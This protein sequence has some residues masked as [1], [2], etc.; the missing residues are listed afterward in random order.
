MNPNQRLPRSRSLA[1]PASFLGLFIAVAA[2]TGCYGAASPTPARP[3]LPPIVDGQE[4]D[5]QTSENPHYYESGGHLR[6]T[7]GIS[8]DSMAYGDTALTYHE[9]RS[10]ADPTWNDKLASHDQLVQRCHRANIPRYIGYTS[11]LIGSIAYYYGGAL[12]NENQANLHY[13]VS[14]GLLGLGA[15]AYTTGYLFFGGRACDEAN[16]MAAELHFGAANDKSLY[17]GDTM[18][19]VIEIAHRYNKTLRLN[20]QASRADAK[21]DRETVAGSSR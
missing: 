14:G 17:S 21:A 16:N 20:K 4:V 3:T 5:Y 7:R 9:F 19:E 1:L 2:L 8:L 15:A 6:Y 12:F 11:V 13:A 18:K 10:L